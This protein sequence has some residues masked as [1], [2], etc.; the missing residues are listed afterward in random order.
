MLLQRELPPQMPDLP[1]IRLC[2]NT[3]CIVDP[4][5][6]PWV[7][8]HYWRLVKSHAC[9]YACRRV[10]GQGNYRFIRMHREIMNCPRGL[11]VHHINGNT[12]D[13]RKCNLEILDQKV[14][15]QYRFSQKLQ[16]GSMFYDPALQSSTFRNL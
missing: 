9:Y 16:H 2:K 6:L 7:V 10:G 14:H 3:Y 11:Q 8:K 15:S 13:N 4:E 5:D 12:L 1:L